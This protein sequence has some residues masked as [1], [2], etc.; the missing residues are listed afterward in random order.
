MAVSRRLTTLAEFALDS[1]MRPEQLAGFKAW[2][3]GTRSASDEEWEALYR[4]YMG[5]ELGEHRQLQ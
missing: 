3:R 4:Q 2:L 5:R 1:N